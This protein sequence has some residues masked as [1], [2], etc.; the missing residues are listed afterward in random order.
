M[1]LDGVAPVRFVEPWMQTL[2]Q[3]VRALRRRS[4]AIRIAYVYEQP[5]TST[6][7]YRIYNMIQAI[8]DGTGEIAA[9]W[10]AE[11]EIDKLLTLMPSLDRV[12]LCRM[13]YSDAVN[14]LIT[15]ARRLGCVTIFDCDDLVFDI[16]YAHLILNTL[17]QRIEGAAWT[18]WYSYI[19]R[20]GATAKLCD[21]AILTNEYLAAKFR[22]FS[23]NID[24]RVIPNYLNREQMQLGRQIYSA[25]SGGGFRRSAQI[26]LGYF[27]GS[28]THNNDFAVISAALA[29]LLARDRRLVLR[30]V[31]FMQPTAALLPFSDRI[32]RHELLDFLNLLRLTGSTEFNLAPL[33]DNQFTNCKSELKYFEAAIVG[34]ISLASPTFVFRRAIA[35]GETGYLVNSTDWDQKLSDAIGAIDTLPMMAAAAHQH[36]VQR[37]SWQTMGPCIRAALLGPP[38]ECPEAVKR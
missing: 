9:A 23:G 30:L 6:F 34:T 1:F 2:H 16:D 21:R 20:I 24:V 3:R 29:R 28:P 32:E 38:P 7:R 14:R 8:D 33:Q 15:C 5:D 35:A 31:G 26:H 13:R 36:A 4:A 17:D 37:Y 12:V 27:S 18:Y 22:S 25:K 10:F 11:S 19:S